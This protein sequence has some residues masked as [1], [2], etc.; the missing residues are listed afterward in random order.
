[1]AEQM[2]G[3]A[4]SPQDAQEAGPDVPSTLPDELE[5]VGR[6]VV[7]EGLDPGGLHVPEHELRTWLIALGR[8]YESRGES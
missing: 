6:V 5:D 4:G 3:A 2:A 8:L 1:M 7:R